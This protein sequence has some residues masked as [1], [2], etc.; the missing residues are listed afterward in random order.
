MPDFSYFFFDIGNF[1]VVFQDC[2]FFRSTINLWLEFLKD[3]RR[4]ILTR[5]NK[6]FESKS[7][8]SS[9]S[10]PF[11]LISSWFE[12]KWAIFIHVDFNGVAGGFDLNPH[13]TITLFNR[14]QGLR[15]RGRGNRG[16]GNNIFLA[17][18]NDILFFL[19]RAIGRKFR[20]KSK[21]NTQSCSNEILQLLN[22]P[23]SG[24]LGKA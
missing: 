8:L 23:F 7:V 13:F 18:L 15:N 12:R 9:N 22:C 24:G 20:G 1:N 21:C 16:C 17:N 3:F 5:L 11:Y 14:R 6:F 19:N 4:D 10:V 2:F